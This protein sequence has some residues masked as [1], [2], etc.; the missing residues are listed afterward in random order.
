MLFLLQSYTLKL[1]TFLYINRIRCIIILGRV[2]YNWIILL[3]IFNIHFKQ[4]LFNINYLIILSTVWREPCQVW[5]WKIRRGLVQDMGVCPKHACHCWILPRDCLQDLRWPNQIPPPS[6]PVQGK[7]KSL[8]DIT[9]YITLI[10]FMYHAYIH[11]LICTIH[12][13]NR[14]IFFAKTICF[15]YIYIYRPSCR[16]LTII[17]DESLR[18]FL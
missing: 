7:F 15:E 12:H 4:Y 18:K 1:E 17:V 13:L 11:I 10:L 3:Y 2:K 6:V 14:I 9:K 16:N 8:Y 5:R